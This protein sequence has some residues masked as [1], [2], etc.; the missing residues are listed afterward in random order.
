MVHTSELYC[1]WPL[2]QKKL[3]KQ[4]NLFASELWKS[5][6]SVNQQHVLIERHLPYY[7]GN[8]PLQNVLENIP[9]LKTQLVFNQWVHLTEEFL[10]YIIIII[11]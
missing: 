1:K 5:S 6:Q 2:T 10:K 7:N 9:K 4:H 3:M 8:I 11:C